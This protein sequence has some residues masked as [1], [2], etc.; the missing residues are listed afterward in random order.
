M[1]P[2]FHR[3]QRYFQAWYGRTSLVLRIGT[4]RRDQRLEAHASQG[5]R[6]SPLV[7]LIAYTVVHCVIVIDPDA[8][9]IP[10]IDFLPCH[11]SELASHL[12]DKTL[13]TILLERLSL[14]NLDQHFF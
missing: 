10:R 1:E 2:N 11:L 5:D 7:E 12:D 6:S 14:L 3:P 4:I 13:A 9:R 8:F